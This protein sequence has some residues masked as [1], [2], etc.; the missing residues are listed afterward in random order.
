MG[1]AYR[2]HLATCSSAIIVCSFHCACSTSG[3]T[4]TFSS[5]TVKVSAHAHIYPDIFKFCPDIGLHKTIIYIGNHC[6][7]YRSVITNA[8][9]TVC[10]NIHPVCLWSSG[11]HSSACTTPPLNAFTMQPKTTLCRASCEITFC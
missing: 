1:H 4:I 9:L 8:V 6:R 3:L 7:E 11:L 2:P 5:C 10:S